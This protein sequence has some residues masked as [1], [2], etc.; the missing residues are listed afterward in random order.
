MGHVSYTILAKSGLPTGTQIRNVALIIFDQGQ[1]VATNQRDPHDPSAGTDPERECLTT[2]DSGAPASQ[3]LPLPPRSYQPDFQVCWAG[4]DDAGGSGVASFD[5]YVSEDG[6]PW[7]LWLDGTT[8][9]CATFTGRWHRTYAFFSVARDNVGNRE[10]VP[11]VPNAVATVVERPALR[12]GC[13]GNQVVLSW[14][15]A[16]EGYQL[17]YCDDLFPPV[18][19]QPVTNPPVVIGDQNVVTEQPTALTRFYRLKKP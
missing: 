9:T 10:P 8:N 14:P 5:V 15:T 19:W 7:T 12:I 3:V 6:G 2:I 11:Q 13:V 18:T 16:A 1:V 4:Q 17:E